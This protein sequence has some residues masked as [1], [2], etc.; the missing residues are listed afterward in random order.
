MSNTL[1]ID[2]YDSFTY[3]LVDLILQTNTTSITVVKNDAISLSEIQNLNISHIVISPGPGSPIKKKDFGI[4]NEII[5]E[6]SVPILGVCLGHQGICQ[7][8]SQHPIIA[9]TPEPYHGQAS[10]VYH[11]ESGLF[12]KIP[13]PFTVGLYHSLMVEEPLPDCL[14]KL[15][16]T[17]NN[18]IMAVKHTKKPIWGVQFH[19][20]SILTQYGSTLIT[21]FYHMTTDY[22]NN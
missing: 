6:I 21:N 7:F 19:P 16:W 2:N 15:A 13:S 18:I 14:T 3:N 4:C 8:F 17:S 11:N 1:L 5:R 20:E 10:K 12:Q 22:P 9:L